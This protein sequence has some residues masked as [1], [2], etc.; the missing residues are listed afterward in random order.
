MLQVKLKIWIILHQKT[1]LQYN[2]SCFEVFR[3]NLVNLTRLWPKNSR[4]VQNGLDQ[5]GNVLKKNIMRLFLR[6]GC[7]KN[8]SEI[9][10]PW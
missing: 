6:I 1:S 3:G 4:K 5:K 8:I 2:N 9:P 10:D 7:I